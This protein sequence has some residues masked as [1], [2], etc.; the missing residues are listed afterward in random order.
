M[1]DSSE[2]LHWV[3]SW[4]TQFERLAEST[5]RDGHG[6]TSTETRRAFSR[7]SLD[8]HLLAVVGGHV[9]TAIKRF[10]PDLPDV[11][12]DKSQLEALRLLRNIYEHWDEQLPSH[13]EGGP[14]KERSGEEFA[15]AFPE[16]RPYSITYAAG[17]WLLGGVI[18]LRALTATLRTL[19][20]GVLAMEGPEVS[21]DA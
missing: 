20:E 6:S 21:P 8:E 4:D 12:M 10:G 14:P 19:A 5:A 16:G 18:P 9:V 7:T 11:G 2:L 13:R 15:K 17:D 1:S 3:W